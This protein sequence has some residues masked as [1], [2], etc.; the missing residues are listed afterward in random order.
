MIT[1][2]LVNVDRP[3]GAALSIVCVLVIVGLPILFMIA[4][5]QAAGRPRPQMPADRKA[6][7]D[8]ALR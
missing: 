6:H 2:L 5:A 4:L 7:R 1:A 8:E 3:V